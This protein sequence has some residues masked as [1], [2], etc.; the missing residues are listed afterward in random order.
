MVNSRGTG[1]GSGPRGASPPEERTGRPTESALTAMANAARRAREATGGLSSRVAPA[2][3]SQRQVIK[4]RAY[5]PPGFESGDPLESSSRWEPA[6]LSTG[7]PTGPGRGPH[8][9]TRRIRVVETGIAAGLVIAAV[10]ATVTIGLSS[11]SHPS[12][13]VR[14]SSHPTTTP[15]T[16]RTAPRSTTS[17]PQ[18]TVPPSTTATTAP[19]TTLPAATSPNAPQLSSISPAAG[20]AGQVVTISGTNFI[21]ANG[22]VVASFNGQLAGTVCPV[23]T[24]CTVTVPSL[25]ATPGNVVVTVTTAAGTSNGL[26]FSYS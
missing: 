26:A 6:H 15:V 9:R 5:R 16:P 12:A 2:R 20:A 19:A 3:A 1:L 11:G 18:T 10:I 13:T 8:H 25:G 14:T 24:A 4:S 17:A 23:V 7:A 21:S 22:V